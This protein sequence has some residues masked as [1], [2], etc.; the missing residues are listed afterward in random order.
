MVIAVMSLIFEQVS[1]ENEAYI[2]REKLNL[3]LNKDFFIKGAV[4]KLADTRYLISFDVDPQV[5]T[6]LTEIE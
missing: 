6:E 5:F 3:L 1:E 4:D 2:Y